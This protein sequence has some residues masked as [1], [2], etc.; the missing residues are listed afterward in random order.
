MRVRVGS[1]VCV[2][3]Q[4]SLLISSVQAL[5]LGRLEVTYIH[6]DDKELDILD[7]VKVMVD[8]QWYVLSQ[9]IAAEHEVT[10]LLAEAI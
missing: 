5:R 9:I 7:D 8:G 4:D 2:P 6:I 1:T 10:H 3:V